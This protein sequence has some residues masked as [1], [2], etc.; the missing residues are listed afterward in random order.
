MNVSGYSSKDFETFTLDLGAG[1]TFIIQRWEV[2]KIYSHTKI[3]KIGGWFFKKEYIDKHEFII[4]LQSGTKFYITK[5]CY[6]KL[7]NWY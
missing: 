4:V 6:D 3:E 5:E 1:S 7:A 2:Y